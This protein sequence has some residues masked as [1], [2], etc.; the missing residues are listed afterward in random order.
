[1][2]EGIL[3]ELDLTQLM[4]TVCYLFGLHCALQGRGEHYALQRHGC[5]SQFE[6]ILGQGWC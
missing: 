6:L 4:H 3:G 2:A 1:M 5:N